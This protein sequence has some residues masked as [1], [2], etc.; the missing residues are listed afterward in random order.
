MTISFFDATFNQS[1]R[2]DYE[3]ALAR[4]LDSN[5]LV[6]GSEVASFES[7]FAAY[8]GSEYSVG[9]SNGLD[10]IHLALRALDIGPGDEVIVPA[11]TYIATW[12]GVSMAGAEVVPVE[13]DPVTFNIN[14]A[15]VEKAITPRTRAILAVHLYGMTADMSA[16]S[17]I[18][19]RHNL[20]LLEDAAQ[21]Q[22]ARRDGV[23]AGALGDVAAFSFYPG[24]NLGAL[25]DAGAVTTSDPEVCEKIK[26]LRNYGSEVK[27]QNSVK[28][29]NCRLDELQAAFL[30]AKLKTLDE[31]NRARSQVASWYTDALAGNNA[32]ELPQNPPG[33]EHVWHQYIVRVKSR[34]QVMQ[35]LSEAGVQ[36]MIHYPIP[37]HL[38]GAY[39]EGPW[40]AGDFPIT[41]SMADEVMSLP[42]GG[43]IRESDVARI[44]EILSNV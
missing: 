34:D 8:C 32:V 40:K 37:P 36:T 5:M 22:G 41:E 9:V 30:R 6:L 42:I 16:L 14:P 18:A 26:L 1:L 10:A 3:A 21:A 23:M 44:A 24:K 31:Y 7:E 15:L 29:Y 25:G 43:H 12:L 35:T 39:A 28:G 17:D 33:S 2:A 38:S 27:Y 19:K 4:V 13:P 20:K 11:N